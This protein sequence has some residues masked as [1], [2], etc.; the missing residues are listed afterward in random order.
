MSEKEQEVNDELIT[1]LI[2]LFSTYPW[3]IGIG[4]RISVHKGA[5]I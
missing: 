4:K 3:V 5:S 1:T 2:R